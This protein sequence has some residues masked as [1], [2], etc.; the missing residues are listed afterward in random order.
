[1]AELRGMRRLAAAA[2][3]LAAFLWTGPAAAQLLDRG[4]PSFVSAGIGYFDVDGSH[5]AADFRLEY[6]S[7]QPFFFLKPWLGLEA[8]SDGAVGAFAG[9]LVDIYLGERVVLTPSTGVGLWEHGSG[10]DLGSTIEFR[11]T[12]ELAYRFD[13]RSR[14]GVAF[15]HISNA[16]ID[17]R[18]PGA[19][20]A[21]VYYSLP[22]NRLFD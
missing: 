6:R 11:S 10:K 22:L 3:M 13:D 1:M 17:S 14:L 7:G 21:T 9:V 20:I 16:G 15:G 12:I 19:N 2:G 18:N 8:T 5:G 4:D